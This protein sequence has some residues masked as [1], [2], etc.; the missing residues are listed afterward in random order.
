[1]SG[2]VEKL[3]IISGPSGSGKSTVLRRLLESCDVPMVLSV[4]ATTRPPRPGEQ[5]GIDYHFLSDDEFQ[6]ALARGEFLEAKEVFGHG[7][8]YGTLWSEVRRGWQDG[9]AVILEIDVEGALTAKQA[10]PDAVMIFLHPGSVE[11]LERRLRARATES[12]D[13]VRR[14]LETARR[15]LEKLPLYQYEVIND[16][17]ERAAYEICEIIRRE[18][19][20]LSTGGR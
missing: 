14:R 2:S 16:D 6:A 4:S 15:E 17:V 1:M 3:F 19:G 11:E 10:V 13:E 5:N 20:A 18:T 7:R 12:E 9:K 8:W